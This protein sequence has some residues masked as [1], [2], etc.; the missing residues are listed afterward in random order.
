MKRL[1]LAAS[2][3]ALSLPGSLFAQEP[4]VNE[5]PT[6]HT[7]FW[8]YYTPHPENYIGSKTWW[9][10]ENLTGD[11]WGIRNALADSGIDFV[12]NYTT[13]L[14]G[15]PV[16]GMKQ[17][18]T[19]TD[20]IYFGAE[21]DLEKLVGWGGG[22]LIVS[23]LDRNGSSLSQ[24]YL[25]NQFTVQQIYGGQTAMF[26]ALILQQKFWDDK[27]DIKIGRFATGDDFASSPI[28]WLYM[29]NGI[30][31]NP[32]ALPVNATFSAYPWAVW[33]AR[34]KITPTKETSAMVGLYQASNRIFNRNYHGTDWS[35]RGNDGVMLITQ[36]GW[37][38]EFFK[39][40]VPSTAADKKSD[41]KQ[42]AIAGKTGKSFKEPVLAGDQKGL[43]GHYWFGA[44]YSTLEYQGYS[45]NDTAA[46][47]SYG[48]YWHADQMIFQE[49][50]GSDQGLTL[51]SAFVL[52][53][54]QNI[55]KLPF[56]VNGGAVYK[57]LLPTRDDDFTIFGIVYGNFSN[58]YAD[59]QSAAG[60][61]SPSY[62]MVFEWAYR[63]QINKFLYAQPDVQWVVNP[64]GTGNIPNA[65][66]LGAQIGV[67]F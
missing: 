50:P 1:L 26:Y 30:D 42:V 4:N 6:G 25:G 65:L 31:G 38:P 41:G 8:D 62:E 16:G 49:G 34:L 7:R 40:E 36:L 46:G 54:Q 58:D 45:G 59:G 61:G 57:G 9:E 33:A 63:V 15:N 27:A 39:R 55:S 2:A 3:A 19:Y 48:F 47:S 10:G 21:F 67:T 52:S 11:W 60:L 12:L 43:P 28:Y 32:Q 18:F 66:V 37:N 51:W 64:G 14:A 5:T 22:K 23:G 44:Y 17:G 35:I 13:N 24:H 29:N 53:P 56:Q 20:N